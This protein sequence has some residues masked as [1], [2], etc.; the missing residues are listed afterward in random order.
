[1]A[2]LTDETGEES[3]VP[4]PE[5]KMVMETALEAGRLEGKNE[6]IFKQS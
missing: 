3:N 1:M 2:S 6:E 4:I 5:P